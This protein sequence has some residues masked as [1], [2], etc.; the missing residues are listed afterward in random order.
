MIEQTNNTPRKKTAVLFSVQTHG[1]SNEENHS[2]L[3]ELRRLVK[4]MGLEVVATLTQ[5][6]SKPEAGTLLG[7]GKLKELAGY[8]G[9]TGIVEGFSR[10]SEDETC[11]DKDE[12]YPVGSLYSSVD[13]SSGDDPMAK[14]SVQ[15]DVVI[16]DGEISTK[17]LI[18]LEKATGVEVLDRT[19]VILE[20]FNR[21]AKSREALIQVE[22]AKLSYLAPR[23]RVSHIR[24][25]R[26]GG[27]IGSKGIGE[28]SHELNKRHIRDRISELKSRL[29]GIRYEQNRRR[30]RRKE[31]FQVSLVGYTNAGKSSLMR[32]LT[33]SDVLVEDKLFATLDTRVKS[34]Y[35]EA[36]PPVLVSDTVGFIKK[37]PHDLVASFQST[38]DEALAAS[39]L[40]FTVDASDPVFRSQLAVT[41]SVIE[42]IGGEKIPNRLILNKIDK[43]TTGELEELH[44]EFPDGIFISA[45]NPED[46]ATLRKK[47]LQFFESNMIE[48]TMVIPYS[49]GHLIGQLKNKASMINESYDETGTEVTFK[50]FPET[51]TWLQKEMG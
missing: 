12:D 50:T 23:L 39:L 15:A 33:G 6:R 36:F 41:Q 25:D 2:S 29:E 51:L 3:L 11:D 10:K 22:I 26:Q 40:L 30:S 34:L 44:C 19:G 27:G 46:I 42:E 8:T 5:R 21:H 16:Y 14:N 38:L 13:E 24:G 45:H 48:T 32:K 20:I 4:T 9:G 18:N 35:P 28:T 17:Q 47:I 37:L 1:V 49:K 43:L 7:A 31:N